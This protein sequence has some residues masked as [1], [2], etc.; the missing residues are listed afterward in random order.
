MSIPSI[1]GTYRLMRREFPDGSAQ[2]TPEI[3][4][5]MT[6]TGKWRNFSV[7]W[8]D[9]AGR[10]YS[11]CYVAEYSLTE[12]EYSETAHYLIVDDQ[13]GGK[14]ISY[15]LGEQ[16]AT[17]PVTVDDGR[18]TFRLPQ[19]FETALHITVTFDGDEFRAE[20]KDVCVDVWHK[21]A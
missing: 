17:S 15:D 18:V 8:K 11:E 13:I 19:P 16:T 3:Q 12:T 2:H 10:Y 9:E 4:G 5:M 14:N 1:A 20:L 7:V 21:V 6:Y